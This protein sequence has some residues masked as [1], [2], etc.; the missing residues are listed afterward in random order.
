[1]KVYDL[2]EQAIDVHFMDVPNVT[3]IILDYIETNIYH[4]DYIEVYND[5][6]PHPN[7][8]DYEEV[9]FILKACILATN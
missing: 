5:A 1:M 9:K 4:L 6:N 8:W 3:S 7:I 2:I